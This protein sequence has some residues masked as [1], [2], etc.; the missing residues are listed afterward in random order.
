RRTS[1]VPCNIETSPIC[2]DI[3]DGRKGTC[4]FHSRDGGLLAAAFPARSAATPADWTMFG[5]NPGR[6]SA[7]DV[8][9][10]ITAADLPGLQRQQVPIDGTVDGA[11][12]YLHG[13]VVKGARHDV[14]FVTTTYGKTLAIDADRG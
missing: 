9:T 2:K 12:I 4:G 13:V 5:W 14:F 10:G 6:T 3:S 8:A 1:F 11:A 7:P